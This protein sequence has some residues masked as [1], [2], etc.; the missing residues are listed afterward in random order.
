M[1]KKHSERIYWLTDKSWYTINKNQE[2]E[3]TD[4]APERAKKSFEMWKRGEKPTLR[5]RF[6]KLRTK[7]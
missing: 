5:E 4:L 3:L 1:M 7:L 2:F 6:R